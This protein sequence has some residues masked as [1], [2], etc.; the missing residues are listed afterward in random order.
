MINTFV[1][2]VAQQGFEILTEIFY[3][4]CITDGESIASI[5]QYDVTISSLSISFIF[6]VFNVNNIEGSSHS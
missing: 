3:P 4:F 2:K 5:S 6:V 1:L